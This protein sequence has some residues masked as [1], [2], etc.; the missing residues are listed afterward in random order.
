[1][2]TVCAASADAAIDVL[3]GLTSLA[4]HNLVRPVDDPRDEPRFTMLETVRE[5]ALEQLA[6]S[7]EADVIRGRHAAWYLALAEEAEEALRGGPEHV[8]WL[9]RFEVEL[10]NLREAL[11]W[12]ESAGDTEAMMRLAGALGGFWFWGSHRGKAP[13]GW[14]APSRQ[15][16]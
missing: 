11:G 2:A 9:T 4:D 3:D 6:T 15:P 1:M 10:P 8:R 13:P 7:G 14:S 5:F 12:L 16:T